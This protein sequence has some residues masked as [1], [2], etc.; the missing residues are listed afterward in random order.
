MGSK[1]RVGIVTINDD[2]NYGNR[3]Q[4]FALQQAVRALG[5]E[6]ET[7]RNRPAPWPPELF[8]PRMRHDLATRPMDLLR[9]AAVRMRR[10]ARRPEFAPRRR[11]AIE[12]FTRERVVGSP[13]EFDAAPA[14][15]WSTRYE[16]AIVGSDQVWNPVYRRANAADFLAFMDPD[17][18]IA[19]AASFGVQSIPGFLRTRYAAWLDGIPA[20]S[21]REEQGARIVAEL[22][23]RAVPVVADPTVL[24]SRE[25][26]DDLIRTSSAPVD[27]PYAL[28]F[29]LGTPTTQQVQWVRTTVMQEDLCVV[30][31]NDLH[32]ERWCDLGPADFVLAIRN[33]SL[34][35]TDSFH[36]ASFA[37]VYHRPLVLRER[38]A[39]DDR[40]GTLLRGV[41][42]RTRPVRVPGIGRVIDADWV[43]VDARRERDRADSLRFL[44]DA[45][46]GRSA[47]RG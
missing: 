9:R 42:L 5:W 10:G 14:E 21:V 17:R 41:G 32:T 22:T 26:W 36:V 13:E 19:Y 20:L 6:P 29:F 46:D 16:R 38:F 4:N 23:G 40:M 34:V 43:E 8:W 25:Q 31:A 37:V 45:L 47:A 28:Q 11:A 35:I 3:L 7:L 1:G 24:V 12:Q 2:E 44:A 27:D 30:D 39:H 18:R 33:A 15:Y